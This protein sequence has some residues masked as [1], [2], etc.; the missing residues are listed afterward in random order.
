[1]RI[2]VSGAAGRLAAA[3]LPRLC[4]KPGVAGV[5]GIDRMPPSFRHAKFASIVADI[6]EA[7][8]RNALL[9]AAALVHLAFVLQRGRLPLA[10]MHRNNVE[11]SEAFLAAAGAAG[12]ARVVHVSTAAVYGRGTDLGEDAPLAPWPRF[13]YACQKAEVEA[14]IAREMPQAVVLRP[15]VILGPNAQPLLRQLSAAPFYVR[16]PD[17][18]PLLQCVHEDDVADAI[19]AALVA[20]VR[21]P[22][23]LAAPQAF[24]LRELVLWRRPHAL[25]LPL[26]LA[27]A[28]LELSWRLTG[29]GGEPGWL[30]GIT[31]SLTIDC[32]LAG[33]ALGWQ[34]R[35]TGWREIAATSHVSGSSAY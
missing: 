9:G 15:T 22:F 31:A 27:R 17:P 7:A 32:R 1:V 23:N 21:G 33:A 12:V 20:P 11:G 29:W 13:H 24:A 25:A 26:P 5:V 18:Q 4:A 28:A 3:L 16:L 34:P 6:R 2:V 14:W 35:H 10:Q 8:S 19:M 30:D